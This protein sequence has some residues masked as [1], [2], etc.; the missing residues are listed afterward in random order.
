MRRMIALASVM[1]TLA[2]ISVFVVA[3]HLID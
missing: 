1:A 2:F 3:N